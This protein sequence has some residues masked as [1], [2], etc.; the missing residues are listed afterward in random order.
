VNFSS[1]KTRKTKKKEIIIC[2]DEI[3]K[4]HK[5]EKNAHTKAKSVIEFASKRETEGEKNFLWK[6]S[7]IVRKRASVRVVCDNVQSQNSN[8]EKRLK[9]LINILKLFDFGWRYRLGIAL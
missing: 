4:R 1:L 9:R 6:S 3:L 5:T 7:L 2:R 8:Q